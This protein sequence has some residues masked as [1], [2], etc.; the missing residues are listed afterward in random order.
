MLGVGVS[1]ELPNLQS[2]IARVTTHHLEEFF[3]YW[4]NIEA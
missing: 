2:M 4:K 1:S 3:K